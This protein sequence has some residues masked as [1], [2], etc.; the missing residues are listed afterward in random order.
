[1]YTRLDAVCE[2]LYAIEREGVEGLESL[3]DELIGFLRDYVETYDPARR[4][5]PG[6]RK[7]TLAQ[8]AIA[9]AWFD[10]EPK[11]G[12]ETVSSDKDESDP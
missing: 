11:T 12:P 7:P 3:S 2:I 8:V 5:W 4:M 6:H 9:Q 1:M 10:Q